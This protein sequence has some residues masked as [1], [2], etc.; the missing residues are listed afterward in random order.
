MPS[1]Y[2]YFGHTDPSLD[3]FRWRGAGHRQ[4]LHGMFFFCRGCSYGES[5]TRRR[6]SLF[7]SPASARPALRI[8]ASRSTGAYY[9]NFAASGSRD[10]FFRFLV[11]DHH[12]RPVASGP[13]LVRL[14]VAGLRPDRKP[15]VPA[16]AR[17]VDPITGCRCALTS[18]ARFLFVHAGGHAVV[19]IRH[20]SITRRTHWF[21]FGPFSVQSSRVLL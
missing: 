21:E 10:Q 16:L 11:K 7:R 2:T 5:R 15:V 14:G 9:A 19:Y 12:G 6:M 18:A 4:L 3:R 8:C 20:G 13:D 17:L 1:F